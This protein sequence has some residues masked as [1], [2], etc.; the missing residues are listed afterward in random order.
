M[1]YIRNHTK[2]YKI[3]LYGPQ[4]IQTERSLVSITVGTPVGLRAGWSTGG[5]YL[6]ID[7][8]TPVSPGASI[9]KVY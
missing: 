4:S 2:L 3:K 1:E 9:L 6:G 7:I 5:G 8:I